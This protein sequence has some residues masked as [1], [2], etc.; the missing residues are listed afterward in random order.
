MRLKQRIR[1]AG[2]E[3]TGKMEEEKFLKKTM[4]FFERLDDITSI[5]KSLEI[6][7][8]TAAIE[9]SVK[10]W[11]VDDISQKNRTKTQRWKT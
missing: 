9:N 10:S 8:M 2:S 1:K 4:I 11:N 7:N 6:K 5:K 3:E